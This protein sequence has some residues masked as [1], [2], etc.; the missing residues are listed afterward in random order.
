MLRELRIKNFSI[1]DEVRLE[2]GAGLTVLT[3]E[4]GAGKTMVLNALSLIRGGRVSQDII[5]QGEEEATV[6]ALFEPVPGPL[7]GKLAENGLEG[8]DQLVIKRIVSRSGKNRVYLNGS[9][10]SLGLLSEFGGALIHIYGQHEHHTLLRP[11]SHL[12]LLDSYGELAERVREMKARYRALELA[13]EAL[14]RARDE[15]ER[16]R[17]ESAR[18]KEQ[19]DELARAQLKSGEEE[20]LRARK[21]IAAHAA[22]LYQGCRE[23]VEILY[24]GEDAL[25][26]RLGRY[27]AR[28]RDW[29]RIDPGLSVSVGLLDSALAQMEEAASLLRKQGDRFQ[30]DPEELER[31]EERLAEIQ[32][33]KRKYGA[34]VDEIIAMGEKIREDLKALER[35]EEE[36]PALEA[37]SGE[38]AKT[39][40]E[41]A[42][43]LSS[44][45]SRAAKRLDREMVKELQS[46][47]MA[48]TAFQTRFQE[49]EIPIGELP[50]SRDGKRLGEDGIDRLEFYLSPNPGEPVKPLAKIASG[51]E[52]SRLMLAL[53]SLVLA[54]DDVPTL[55]FDEVDAGIG[56]RVAEIVGRRLKKVAAA[57]QVLCVTHL[58]QIAA[59]ADSHFVVQKKSSGGRT[60]TLVKKLND[61]DRVSEVARMLGGIEVTEKARRHAEEMIKMQGSG[62]EGA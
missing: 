17:R 41:W 38:T 58:P 36:I 56:G 13:W 18:L 43:T 47:G 33:L 60:V 35:D 49:D 7:G 45:R 42:E 21:E 19:A 50:F 51:G 29:A 6:E 32:R 20:D 10:G 24:E 48:G 27:I 61:R 37:A 9:L 40:W 5:R 54:R 25:A 53:K 46:L 30:F 28:L 2:L 52:L 31:L 1:L 11:E 4:T 59:L 23:G 14:K 8:H 55:L 12:A 34:P 39:A 22:K 16:G 26:S 44:E 62:K 3:G 57:H 15:L